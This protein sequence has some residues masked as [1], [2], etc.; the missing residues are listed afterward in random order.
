ME[1]SKVLTSLLVLTLTGPTLGYPYTRAVASRSSGR[2]REQL[3][4]AGLGDYLLGY[5]DD[6]YVLPEYTPSK[7]YTYA[8]QRPRINAETLAALLPFL[9]AARNDYVYDYN[10]YSDDDGTWYDTSVNDDLADTVTTDDSASS[11]LPMLLER[12]PL[13]YSLEDLENMEREAAMEENTENQLHELMAKK[14]IKRTNMPMLGGHVAISPR[15]LRKGQ[16]E[17]AYD[18]PAT[19]V[20]RPVFARTLTTQPEEQ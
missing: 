17:E 2:G 19:S 16:K 20:R 18:I 7:R 11:L 12:R 13:R 3:L 1:A 4:D 10:T 8:A 5:T 14:N 15:L 6:Q 9:T